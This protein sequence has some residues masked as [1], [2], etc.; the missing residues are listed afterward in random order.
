MSATELKLISDALDI[1]LEY[2]TTEAARVHMA[3]AG[4]KPTK[5]AAVDADVKTVQDAIAAWNRRSQPA[6]SNGFED[7]YKNLSRAYMSDKDFALKCYQAGESQSQRDHI[8][9]ANKMVSRDEVQK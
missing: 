4:Y 6:P 5:H 2:V 3:Y 9:D 7:F 1:A 8:G